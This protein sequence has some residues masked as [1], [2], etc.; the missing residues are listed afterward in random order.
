MSINDGGPAFPVS[1]LSKTQC[2]GL[3]LKVRAAGATQ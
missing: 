2:P 1:D 3:S